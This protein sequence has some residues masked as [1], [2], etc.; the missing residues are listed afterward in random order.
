M[1]RKG[2]PCPRRSLYAR[3]SK[4]KG[5]SGHAL[6]TEVIDPALLKWTRPFPS[7]TWG[8]SLPEHIGPYYGPVTVYGPDGTTVLR[9]I[10]QQELD[11][12][13]R[14]ITGASVGPGAPKD[15]RLP[16]L[17]WKS[18]RP[19]PT[20]GLRSRKRKYGYPGTGST[21]LHGIPGKSH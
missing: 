16:D 5:G 14:I 12:R 4:G 7:R 2:V 15:W 6:G 17:D 9:V 18:P 1:P 20:N 3:K 8:P 21:P 19:S 11:N 13:Q 10:S